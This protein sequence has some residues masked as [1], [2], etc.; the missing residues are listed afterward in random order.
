MVEQRQIRKTFGKLFLMA[1][2]VFFGSASLEG[3]GLDSFCGF[4]A[5]EVR[6]VGI[7]GDMNRIDVR[8]MVRFRRF[9]KVW[10]EYSDSRRLTEVQAFANVRGMKAAAVKEEFEECIKWFQKAGISRQ[11]GVLGREWSDD[12][13]GDWYGIGPVRTNESRLD[14]NVIVSAY[15]RDPKMCIGN[16]SGLPTGWLLDVTNGELVRRG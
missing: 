6:K 13:G 12:N 1:V 4:K 14:A 11:Q 16:T 5:G 7:V 9:N 10:L 8:P 3:A 15:Y 2:A